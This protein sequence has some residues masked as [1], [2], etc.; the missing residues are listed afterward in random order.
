MLES[1]CMDGRIPLQPLLSHAI[2]L[3]KGLFASVMLIID[4]YIRFRDCTTIYARLVA[5]RFLSVLHF[6]SQPWNAL[7]VYSSRDIRQPTLIVY[8]LR[9]VLC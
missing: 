9:C 5:I 6:S 3:Q 2:F 7:V 1:F 4:M 8:N